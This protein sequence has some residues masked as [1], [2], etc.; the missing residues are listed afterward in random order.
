MYKVHTK[1]KLHRTPEVLACQCNSPLLQKAKRTDSLHA[2]YRNGQPV[3]S[4][5]AENKQN[6]VKA[7]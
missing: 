6:I 2:N 1:V 3:R 5:D 4:A 7:L